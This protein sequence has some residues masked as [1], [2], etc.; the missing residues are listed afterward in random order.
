MALDT[1]HCPSVNAH[2]TLRS[3][4]WVTVSFQSTRTLAYLKGARRSLIF[5]LLRNT[6]TCPY[7]RQCSFWMVVGVSFAA[8]ACTLEGQCGLLV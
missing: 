1:P 2:S 7:P 4:S 3:L 6:F 5:E 8:N